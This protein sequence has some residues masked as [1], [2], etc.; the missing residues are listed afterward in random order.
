M[1]GCHLFTHARSTKY[2]EEN[3]YDA[4]VTSHGG[5]CNAYT[6][7]EYTCFE[8]DVAAT[9][10]SDAL[11]VFAQCFI[12]PLLKK[13]SFDREIRAI[14]SEFNLA[15]SEDGS[16]LEQLFCQCASPGHVLCKFAWGNM[17]SLKTEPRAKGVN[18]HALLKSFCRSYYQP[19]N[20][21]LVVLSPEPLDAI[22]IIVNKAF[23]GW[24]PSSLTSSTL[25]LEPGAERGAARNNA[26]QAN[27][28][29]SKMQSSGDAGGKGKKSRG[30]LDSPGPSISSFPP[31]NKLL[32]SYSNVDPLSASS[33]AQVRRVVPLRD[34]HAV[35]VSWALQP[36]PRKDYR[37]KAH[38]YLG[39]LLGHEGPGSLLSALKSHSLA[40]GVCAGVRL[41]LLPVAV[42]LH[43]RS[44]LGVRCSLF[45]LH[46]S[47]F[48]VRCANA[49]S[50]FVLQWH[51]H[52]S[53]VV[54]N[55]VHFFHL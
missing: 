25:R 37:T 14:E 20:M 38:V 8:F 26:K 40:T 54:V 51:K 36:S 53:L 28:K 3:F 12:S 33:L 2:P 22:E 45:V 50:L 47:L 32:D 15:R 6:E 24:M 55:N 27:P 16:R 9:H 13:S 30:S 10:F 52:N 29:K 11:D 48:L 21:K 7:G 42:F 5:S 41:L 17:K 23:Q 18:V 4:F 49:N 1:N 31:M 39:H 35:S 43:H 34:S 44:L 19:H 46:C